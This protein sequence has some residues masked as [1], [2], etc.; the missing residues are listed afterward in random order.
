MPPVFGIGLPVSLVSFGSFGAAAAAAAAAAAG[1]PGALGTAPPVARRS[2]SGD[3]LVGESDSDVS[4]RPAS[5]LEMAVNGA[6]AASGSAVAG[7]LEAAPAAAA[8]A[9]AP[10]GAVLG[11]QSPPLMAALSPWDWAVGEGG[12]GIAA[13]VAA[14]WE[15]PLGDNPEDLCLMLSSPARPSTPLHPNGAP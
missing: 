14:E 8:P 1:M 15:R 2:S 5:L 6:V 9:A 4:H 3:S 7:A 11:V 13:A 12:E 10:P